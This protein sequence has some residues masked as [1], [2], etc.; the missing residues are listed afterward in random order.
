MTQDLPDSAPLD[1][2]EKVL[3]LK[4]LQID[5]TPAQVLQ[6][7]LHLAGATLPLK[8]VLGPRVLAQGILLQCALPL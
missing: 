2:L 8:V 5:T 6:Q 4:G 7:A 3:W 1:L